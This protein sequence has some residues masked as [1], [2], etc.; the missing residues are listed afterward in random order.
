MVATREYGHN[1]S[2]SASGIVL[3]MI[4]CF[5]LYIA[6]ATAIIA[7]GFAGWSSSRHIAMCYFKRAAEKVLNLFMALFRGVLISQLATFD[8]SE[9]KGQA[10]MLAV[11]LAI[12]AI[13]MTCAPDAVEEV[14]TGH[15]GNSLAG[16]IARMI[17]SGAFRTARRVGGGTF[18]T[19][20]QIGGGND[21]TRNRT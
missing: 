11:F 9:R 14:L 7:F 1:R 6:F 10:M 2:A 19:L 21:T 5:E 17:G 20:K 3:I 15:A 18:Q 16:Q 8:L 13:M 4:A 12:L